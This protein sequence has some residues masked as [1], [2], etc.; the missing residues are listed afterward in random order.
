MSERLPGSRFYEATY[1]IR[2]GDVDQE[3]RVRLD[4]VAR[5]LQDIANDNLEATP[6]HDTD[7][8]WIVRRTVIDVIEPIGWPGNVTLQRWCGGLSTRWTN[9]RVSIRADHETN[10]FNPEPRPAGRIETEAF[11]ILVN[12]KGMPTRLSDE[13]F[14]LLAEMTHEHRL[15]WKTMHPDPLPEAGELSDLAPEDREHILRSTDFDAFKHLNN[16]AYWAA[17]EDELQS[18]ADL[19]AGP[20]RA[21]I[22]YLRPIVPG[23]RII[24]RRRRE[25]HRLLIWMLIGDNEGGQQVAATVSITDLRAAPTP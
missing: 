17:V 18:H 4:T 6:F 25:A 11:W 7:P 23:V 5:Y 22:E 1:R 9:M 8:F 16:A 13:G 12:E 10:R 14:D 3:M 2:T 24:L 15:K 20:H 21:V 19:V